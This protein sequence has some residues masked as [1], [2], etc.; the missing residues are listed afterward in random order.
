MVG[1]VIRFFRVGKRC[2]VSA[3]SIQVVEH[4]LTSAQ[5]R[6]QRERERPP[7]SYPV[8]H[9]LR[10][11][12]DEA[13]ANLWKLATATKMMLA[14]RLRPHAR[15]YKGDNLSMVAKAH[16]KGRKPKTPTDTAVTAWYLAFR[17]RLVDLRVRSRRS[18]AALAELLDIPLD[19][20]KQMESP[21]RLTRFPLHKLERLSNA[22][23][24]PLEVIITGR[25]A[26]RAR[27]EDSETS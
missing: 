14:T 7:R 5:A 12:Q 6:L 2:P 18:Q 4:V 3:Q 17:D 9:R 13:Q 25:T 10:A 27:A 23:N 24:V 26:R 19:S 16:A 20:Y 1:N 11:P 22:L 8:G 21:T 15:G